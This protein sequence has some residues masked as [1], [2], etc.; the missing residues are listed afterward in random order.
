VLSSLSRRRVVVLLILT[1][2]LLIT[3]DRRGHNAFIDKARQGFAVIMRPFDIAADAVSKPVAN[4]WYGITHYDD[5][6]EENEA[7]KDQ[8][9]HEKGAEIEAQTAIT[10][11]YEL[12]KLYHLTSVHSYKSV[13]AQVVGEAPSNF[14]NTVEITVGTRAGVAVGMPVTDGAGLIG[15]VTKVYPDRSVVMLITDPQ[16]SVQAQVLSSIEPGEGASTTS[17][18][19]P[20]TAVSGRPLDSTT[21]TSTTTSTT[22]TTTT[23]TVPKSTTTTT[24]KGGATTSETSTST[25]STS[26]TTSTTVPEVLVARETGNIDGQSADRPLLF[27]LIDDTALTNVKVGD[28]VETAGGTKSLAPQG[29]PIGTITAVRQRLGSRTPIV[30]VEPNASLTRLNFVSVVLFVPNQA[31]I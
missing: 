23:T 27:S 11:Y 3:L 10:K 1:S 5:L 24:P 18:T 17:S 15:K 8:I 12:L 6:K 9:E 26:T 30:E 22:T 4:A 16:F 20:N 7:L 31:A 19:T 2:L 14:Q 21:S 13:I 25:S 29:L 28:I